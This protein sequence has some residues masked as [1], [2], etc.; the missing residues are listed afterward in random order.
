[1]ARRVRTATAPPTVRPRMATSMRARTGIPTKTPG[2]VGRAQAPTR[3][4]NTTHPATQAQVP[5][6]VLQAPVAGE[7]RKRA[8]DHQPSIAVGEAG[9]RGR[10]VLAAHTAGAV[11]VVGEVADEPNF[12]EREC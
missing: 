2:A 5:P 11:V 12:S 10:P 8:A 1:M 7:G 6:R 9:S 4:R 3:I